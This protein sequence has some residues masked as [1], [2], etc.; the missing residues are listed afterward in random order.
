M[1]A[2]NGVEVV[3]PKSQ[4]C[5]GALSMHTGERARALAFAR[6]NLEAFP[7]DI[8]AII[9]N[10]AGCGSGI[11]EYPLLFKGE[12]DFDKAAGFAKQSKDVS[13]FL[14]ELGLLAP[15]ALHSPVQVAYHDACHLAHAQGVRS[16]P[17]SILSSIPGLDLVEISEGELCCGSAG[18]YNLEQPE[19]A[20]TLGRRKAANIV[21]SGARLAATG[22]IG[23]I[24]QIE[25]ALKKQSPGFRVL[26]TLEVLDLA[27]REILG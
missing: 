25:A 10:A 5:C 18:S 26:H 9:T 16:E 12:A 23:C 21:A 3:I 4:G 6:K 22:N 17:R 15:K 8:D 24:T 14:A 19:I 20:N 2:K 27:Y 11:H 13:V 1:L 7:S